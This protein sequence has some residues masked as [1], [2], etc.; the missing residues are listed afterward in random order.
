MK[1]IIKSGLCKR[2]GGLIF[3]HNIDYLTFDKWVQAGCPDNCYIQASP[4]LLYICRIPIVDAVNDRGFFVKSAVGA[5]RQ[6][7]YKIPDYCMPQ[8]IKDVQS[9]EFSKIVFG[10]GKTKN[11]MARRAK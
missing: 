6:C 4:D 8:P 5:K 3:N 1:H 7:K 10:L 2:L 9:T 11:K